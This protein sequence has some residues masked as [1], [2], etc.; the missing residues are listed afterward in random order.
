[1]FRIGSPHHLLQRNQAAILWTQTSHIC[2]FNLSKKHNTC[3]NLY[4]PSKLS[5]HL[6]YVHFDQQNMS[7]IFKRAS[8]H[9][10]V[11]WFLCGCAARTWW[12][13][14]APGILNEALEWIRPENPGGVRVRWQLV[15]TSFCQYLSFHSFRSWIFAS[16]CIFFESCFTLLMIY[17]ARSLTVCCLKSYR[18]PIGQLSSSNHHFS[19]AFPIKPWGVWYV[20]LPMLGPKE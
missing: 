16:G 17:A 14:A 6:S 2:F 18:N 3:S 5:L 10:G 4:F 11:S 15:R 7:Q 8:N 1:M 9:Q 20:S 19:G 12:T 13:P